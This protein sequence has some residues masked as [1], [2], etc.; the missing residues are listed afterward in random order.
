ML[1]LQL[2]FIKGELERN[3]DITYTWVISL[4]KLLLTKFD[5]L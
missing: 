4:Q 5:V 3:L 1:S 2:P